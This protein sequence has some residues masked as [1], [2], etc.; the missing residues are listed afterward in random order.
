MGLVTAV[1]F[2][3]RVKRLGGGTPEACTLAKELRL[4]LKQNGYYAQNLR[5]FLYGIFSGR[6]IDRMGKKYGISI[7]D[8]HNSRKKVCYHKTCIE[9]A[10]NTDLKTVMDLHAMEQ[11][12]QKMIPTLSKYAKSYVGRKL[13]FIHT[14]CNIGLEDLVSE[15]IV[16]VVEAFY[17]MMPCDKSDLHVLNYLKRS[18]NNHGSVMIDYY[19][20]SKR[21]RLIPNADRTE[22]NLMVVSD[23]QNKEDVSSEDLDT[24]DLTSINVYD[25]IAVHSIMQRYKSRPKTYM[26]LRLL[27]CEYDE[28]FTKY[29]HNNRVI[30]KIE[31]NEDL[32][33]VVGSNTILWAS[34]YLKIDAAKSESFI[35]TLRAALS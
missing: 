2:Q 3:K 10:K 28:L 1:D 35:R 26:F 9:K 31:T 27:T 20:A 22:F 12:F 5:A 24:G 15:I 30:K 13:F 25:K 18:I 19:T 14:S 34:K 23:N 4:M 16:K 33:D 17:W 32:Y 29:L 7:S 6:N 8:I 21:R 11:R